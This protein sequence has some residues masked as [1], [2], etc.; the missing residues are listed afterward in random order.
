[1][2]KKCRARIGRSAERC[3]NWRRRFR[4]VRGV[5]YLYVRHPA[6]VSSVLLYLRLGSWAR[7][8]CVPEPVLCTTCPNK[9]HCTLP[10]RKGVELTMIELG[11]WPRA[12]RPGAFY[13][14]TK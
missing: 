8:L 12:Q 5:G 9:S 14:A 6:L 7:N 13:R 1:M 11:N 3:L 4:L 10:P 2:K